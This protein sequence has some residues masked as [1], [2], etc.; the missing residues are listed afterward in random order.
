MRLHHFGFVGKDLA[1]LQ[2]RFRAES[3]DEMTPAI[4]DPTQRVYVQF[5]RDRLTGDVWEIVAPLTTV[6]E[7][8]LAGR[9]G[10]GGGLDHACYEL[11]ASDGSLEDVLGAE[12]AGGALVTVPPVY[13][14]AFERRIAFVLRRSGR[15]IEFV[16]ARAPGQVV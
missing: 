15:L 1:L 5:F 6:E 10:R 13:A 4:G 2:R 14:T 7:S 12:R 9:I 16:E 3:A 11:E 8:P